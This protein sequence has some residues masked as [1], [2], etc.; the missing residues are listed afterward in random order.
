MLF[1]TDLVYKHQEHRIQIVSKELIINN[2][3]DNKQR[4]NKSRSIS[5]IFFVWQICYSWL[6]SR[7][8]FHLW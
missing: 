8:Y 5:D 3:T 2:N 6:L 4:T 1:K 7:L